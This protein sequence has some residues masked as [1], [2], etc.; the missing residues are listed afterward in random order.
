MR[1]DKHSKYGWLATIVIFAFIA[2][3]RIP[4]IADSP[5]EYDSWRQSDTESIALNFIS[6]RFNILYPQLNY[7]GPMPNYVQ[8]E[9]QLTTWIIALLYKLFGHHYALARAVPVCFFIGSAWFLFLIARKYGSAATGRFAVLIYGLL[10]IHV[11]YSRAIMPESAALLFM[12]GAFYWFGEWLDCKKRHVLLLAA[13]FTALAISQKIPTVFVGIPMLWMAAVRFRWTL[14]T[15]RELWLFAAIALLP[16]LL[17][18]RWLSAIAEFPFVSGIASKHILPNALSSIRS[19]EALRFFMEQ[20]PAMFTWYGVALFAAGLCALNWKREYAIGIWAVAM[21]VELI[22]IVATIRFDYYLIFIGPLVAL[23][24]AKL[25][26]SISKR[27]LGRA[28]A[29]AWL[30]L[31]S[32]QSFQQVTPI[33]GRQLDVVKQQAEVVQRLTKPDDLIVVGTDDPSLLNASR[34]KGWRVGNTMPHDPVAELRYFVSNG[35]A[36]FVP[37]QGWIAGD[38]GRLQRYLRE[39]YPVIE[40]KGSYSIYKL[41]N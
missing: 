17:Y 33:L 37:L 21:I 24:G 15:R 7:D 31:L 6:H 2:A 27:G 11:L 41:R 19:P 1:L 36:Y 14:F 8:L 40:V 20:L 34:R 16:P 35:A 39:T 12:T 26:D 18:F 29:V 30:L 13:C 4:H 32:Y 23:L 3:L 28:V 10:P 25:L 38:D 9:F 5:Y 22:T